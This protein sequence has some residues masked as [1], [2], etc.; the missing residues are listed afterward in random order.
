MNKCAEKSK[1]TF[2]LL[3]TIKNYYSMKYQYFV[4]GKYAKI[5]NNKNNVIILYKITN[6][7]FKTTNKINFTKNYSNYDSF[8]VY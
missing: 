3:I 1:K 5:P 2:Y 8:D 4:L 6:Y 7:L